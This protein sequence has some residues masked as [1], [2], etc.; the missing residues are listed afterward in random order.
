MEP[1]LYGGAIVVIDRHYN[2]VEP[3]NPPHRNL[4][5][6]RERGRL[7]LRYIDL[8]GTHLVARP[9]CVTSPPSLIEMAP[10]ADPGEYITG[11]VVFI[12]NKV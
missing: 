1:L 11:R 2:H 3:C 12:L 5:A 6:V 4:Y 7:L 8:M 9:L 10:D